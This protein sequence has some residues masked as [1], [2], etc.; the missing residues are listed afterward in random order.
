MADRF[1]SGNIARRM[2]VPEERPGYEE[3]IADTEN[4]RAAEEAAINLAMLGM[5]PVGNLLSALRLARQ[6][7]GGYRG[8]SGAERLSGTEQR[9]LP[10][11]GRSGLP[12]EISPS[13]VPATGSN[14]MPVSTS[15]AR[16]E[17][18]GEPR[19]VGSQ[20]AGESPAY[21]ASFRPNLTNPPRTNGTSVL[22]MA[23]SVLGMPSEEAQP[24]P[25]GMSPE[26]LFEIRREAISPED[27]FDMRQQAITP[28]D[29]HGQLT[30]VPMPRAR[31]T[32]LNRPAPA[33]SAP[34]PAQAA[35]VQQAAAK[36]QE[37]TLR[38]LWKAA[39]ESGEARDFFRADQAMQS[40]IKRGED[41]G[42]YVKPEGYK[43][44][45]SVN[46]KDAAVHKALEII[47]HMITNR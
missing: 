26:Y 23:M 14:P 6:G 5:G 3:Y 1:T 15:A 40:A 43:A 34:A 2:Y 44:G 32:N 41:I 11:P 38:E 45:G 19:L 10:A 37:M 27:L 36:P 16:N 22:P 24:E 8:L 42:Y 17:L 9:L 25:R 12:A 35:Q 4:R 28:E 39:N 7:Y 29:I 21:G 33:R 31:P 20:A 46:G 30:P 47:H 18:M 13:G